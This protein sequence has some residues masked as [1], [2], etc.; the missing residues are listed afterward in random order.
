MLGGK[1]LITGCALTFSDDEGT[2][3][4]GDLHQLGETLVF[5]A[6]VNDKLDPVLSSIRPDNKTVIIH[7]HTELMQHQ[8]IFIFRESEATFNPVAEEFLATWRPL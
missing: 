6:V 3:F 1:C 8:G 5:N 2:V 7:P 4:W